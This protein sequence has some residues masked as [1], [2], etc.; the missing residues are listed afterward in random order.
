VTLHVAG[1]PVP[2]HARVAV[3]AVQF[4]ISNLPSP[5]RRWFALIGVLLA[6]GGAAAV[7][8]WPPGDEVFG[9][10][11]AFEW[12]LLISSYVF[13]VV[14]TSG[15]CLISGLG[16][17]FGVKALK[18]VAKRA[19]VLALAFLLAGFFIIALDLHWPIRLA[20]GVVLSPS[21][22]SAMW[23]MGVLYAGY[24][25]LLVAELGAMLLGFATIARICS[26]LCMVMAVAA[27]ST[28]GMVFGVLA[29]RP[30]WG[31]SIMPVY[32][33]LTAILSGSAVLGIVFSTVNLAGLR[34]HGSAA[35]KVVGAVRLGLVA[36]CAAVLAY[37]AWQITVAIGS[38]NAAVR[39]TA[40]AEISGPLDVSFWAFKVGLGLVVPLVLLVGAVRWRYAV[41]V[42]SAL[43][44]AGLFVDRLTFVGA[45]QVVP[46]TTASG[47]VSAPYATY[48]PSVV[49][50]AVVA[51]A[52]GIVLLLYSLAERYLDLEEHDHGHPAPVLA[53][54]TATAVA[55]DSPVPGVEPEIP[56][57][58][59]VVA[60]GV[61]GV[62]HTAEGGPR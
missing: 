18:P 6:V 15:L 16:Q 62:V 2:L 60:V 58:P 23:W 12:G 26:A 34:G 20:F 19:V 10:S 5:V 4:E 41:P 35:M 49:E 46:F 44:L 59:D 29:S 54:A 3:T 1:H 28:L 48:A 51:G 57:D 14:T 8:S 56:A 21:P 36:A 38:P 42:A 43:V 7:I 17:V 9:T 50:I 32:M 33:I 45:A 40:M 24:L 13:F 52:A 22:S 55:V 37:T 25:G 31:G 53:A 11:P 61:V 27:P 30:F 39:S 47:L